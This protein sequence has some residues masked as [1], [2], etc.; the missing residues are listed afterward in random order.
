MGWCGGMQGSCSGSLRH[1]P[2]PSPP[3]P[4]GA[5]RGSLIAPGLALELAQVIKML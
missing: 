2:L 5:V 1:S 3:S 4:V